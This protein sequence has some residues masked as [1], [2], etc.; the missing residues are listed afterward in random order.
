M[1]DKN[2]SDGQKQGEPAQISESSAGISTHFNYAID[3]GPRLQNFPSSA[4]FWIGFEWQPSVGRWMAHCGLPNEFRLISPATLKSLIRQAR[5]LQLLVTSY[6][7][8][9]QRS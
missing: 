9:R 8:N 3:V 6:R 5:K 2:P 4:R 1:H 7:A